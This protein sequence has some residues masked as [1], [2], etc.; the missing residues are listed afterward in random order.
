MVHNVNSKLCD[1]MLDGV[2]YLA[3]FVNTIPIF[4]CVIIRC[5]HVGQYHECQGK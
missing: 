3:G 4:V 5:V 1:V 2:T